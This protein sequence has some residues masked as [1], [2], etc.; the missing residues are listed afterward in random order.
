MNQK[1]KDF[2]GGVT[3]AIQIKNEFKFILILLLKL[4]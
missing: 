2:L 3:L 1:R 4:M